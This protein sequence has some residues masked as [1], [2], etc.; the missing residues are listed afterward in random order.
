MLILALKLAHSKI[1]ADFTLVESLVV[2][3]LSACP[4]FGLEL[5]YIYYIYYIHDI[6]IHYIH[7]ILSKNKI[8][9]PCKP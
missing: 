5:H 9:R 2:E 6:H 3:V 7:Y 1:S 8:I 4:I